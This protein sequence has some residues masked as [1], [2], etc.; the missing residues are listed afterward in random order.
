MMMAYLFIIIAA[1]G[2]LLLGVISAGNRGMKRVARHP[3][4]DRQL[5][6]ERWSSI[7]AMRPASAVPE[8][9]KLFDYVLRAQGFAGQTMAERLKRAERRLSDRGAVWRAHK[10]RNSLAHEVG[11]EVVDS[12]AREALAAF[13]RGLEDLGA[14]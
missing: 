13:K 11:F 14:L 7:E 6:A 8:A 5:V 9:D 4:L 2:L 12:H 10:L 3:H 1:V